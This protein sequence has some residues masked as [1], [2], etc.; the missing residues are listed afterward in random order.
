MLKDL[1]EFIAKSL[2][3]NPDSVRVQSDTTPQHPPE[4]T[5]HE[6][7]HRDQPEPHA[8]RDDQR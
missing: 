5:H 1:I 4:R 6:P 8:R 3:D 2:V 7:Q